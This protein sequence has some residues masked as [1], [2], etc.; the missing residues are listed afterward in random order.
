MVFTWLDTLRTV[1]PTLASLVGG[2][3]A[4]TAVSA[5]SSLLFGKPDVPADEIAQAMATANPETLAK[6][7][8]LDNDVAAH[9][10]QLDIDLER[11]VAEDRSA[12]R[13]REVARRDWTPLTLALLSFFGFFATLGALVFIEV[14]P[15]GQ[16]PLNI[17]LGG[18][19][20]IVASVSAYYFGSSAGSARKT[21]LLST[22]SMNHPGVSKAWEAR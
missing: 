18:L 3:L 6:L 16:A 15:S 11:I 13:Q 22:N 4:G 12:A 1:A 21:E 2:P 7:K 9:M 17:M 14:P 8:Q 5:I 20:A 19:S 10:K